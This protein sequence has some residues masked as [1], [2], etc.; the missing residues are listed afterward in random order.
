[1]WQLIR[2]YIRNVYRIYNGIVGFIYDISRLIRYGGWRGD[3]N[4]IELRNYNSM[5]VY[6]GL[7]KTL[8]YKYRDPNRGWKKAFEMLNI[9]KISKTKKSNELGYHDKAAKQVLEKFINLPENINSEKALIIKRELKGMH[10]NSDEQHGVIG[11][12]IDDFKNGTLN[13]PEKFFYSRYSLR[14]FK[15]KIV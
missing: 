8:S 4:D 11:Y 13:D 15:D 14:E 7:E 3:M 1:M 2:P 6:H 12:T 10:F 5:R 9:L